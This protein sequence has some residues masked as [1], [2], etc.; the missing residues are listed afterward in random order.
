MAA[1]AQQTLDSIERRRVQLQESVDKLRRALTGA[2]IRS[3][4]DAIPRTL[5]QLAA[6][7]DG[8]ALAARLIAEVARAPAWLRL[9]PSL[10]VHAA[11]HRAMLVAPPPP[12]A[13]ARKPDPVVARALFGMVTGHMG[14]DGYPERLV[15][16]VDGI[17]AGCTV[18]CG[19]DVRSRDGRPLRVE[20]R[21]G[22]EVF[23]LDTGAGKGG[24]LS[25]IDL[26]LP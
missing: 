21:S 15:S 5:D 9:G 22:G 18:Y 3:P 19:H 16:W 7:P 4:H 13:G 2:R 25:W 6:T 17:P 1:S 26:P 10:F 23:F 11:F 20:G 24:H 12:D 14:Q 8:E